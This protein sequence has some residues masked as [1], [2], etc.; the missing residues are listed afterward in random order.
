M[1]NILKKI[2]QFFGDIKLTI[3][4]FFKL[5]F[6]VLFATFSQV[7]IGIFEANNRYFT[8]WF[9]T[10]GNVPIYFGGYLIGLLLVLNLMASHATKF[11]F[12]KN[13]FG[14]FLI[15]FGLILLILGSGLT[16]FFGEEMQISIK[17]G[18]TRNYLEYPSQFELVIID[19]SDSSTDT[20]FSYTF[21][22]L[23]S[24]IDFNG[25]VITAITHAPNAIINQRGIENLKYN[26]LGRLFKLISMPKTYKMTERNI[27]GVTLSINYNGQSDYFLL[28]G[29]SAIYQNFKLNGQSYLIKLR[30]KRRYLDFSIKLH[31]F[32]RETYQSTE[33]ARRFISDVSLLTNDGTVPFKI[34]MNEPLRYS[35]YTFFQS[36]FTDD[37]Q[38]SVFQVV[39]NPSWFFPYISSLIIVIGLFVQMIF[40][41]GRY[42]Q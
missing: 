17:E 32:I 14:I 9:V 24:G 12:T 7:D 19:P 1:G 6:L 16:S 37:E 22:E 27:P 18:E 26:Q 36:S 29:G 39:K 21:D 2:V 3:F 31:D 38:T 23:N 42:Q 4:L 41:M 33:T 40:S 30:P 15:H 28:W 34:Q 11:R 25:A 13:Y 35:G 5:F 10:M 20:I 8:S